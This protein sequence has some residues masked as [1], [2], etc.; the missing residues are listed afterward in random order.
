MLWVKRCTAH[1]CAFR[2]RTSVWIVKHP[3]L[4]NVP[5]HYAFVYDCLLLTRF[6]RHLEKL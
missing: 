2:Q 3:A 5:P 6:P 4:E 1:V